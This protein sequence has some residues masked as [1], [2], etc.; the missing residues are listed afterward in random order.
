MNYADFKK[1][2][3][4][5]REEIYR[6]V[7]LENQ[8]KIRIKKEST[9]I[10]NFEKIFDAVFDITYEKGFQAMTMRDLSSRANMSLGALY[11]YFASKEELLAIIQKQGSSMIRNIFAQFHDQTAPLLEQ[12][13]AV[14]K[15]HL[16]LSESARPWFY[17]T[18]MEAKNLTSTGRQAVIAMEE[19]T[20][21]MLVTILESG[22]EKG[23]FRKQN[24]LLT[25]SIIKAMQQE[26]YLKRWKYRK[27]EIDV[28]AYADCVL[29]FTESY[30]LNPDYAECG[31]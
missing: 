17:F 13:R 5:Y 27:R 9:A 1:R 20:E 18:F 2:V 26:W 24:H 21:N 10:K 23:I 28:D 4:N 6:D 19:Y 16:F 31:I 22:E 3:E 14:I 29:E 11:G 25:A 15:T 12:L 30:C 8:E 7:Y